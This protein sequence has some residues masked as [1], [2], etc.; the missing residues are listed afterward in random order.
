MVVYCDYLYAGWMQLYKIA[1]VYYRELLA[2]DGI[3]SI[4]GTVS[5]RPTQYMHMLFLSMNN[6]SRCFFDSLCIMNCFHI[7]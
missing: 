5:N 1:V 3:L 4:Y 7:K 2:D 6:K